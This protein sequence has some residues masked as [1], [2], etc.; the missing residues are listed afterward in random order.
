MDTQM[1]DKDTDLAVYQKPGRGQA[2]INFFV[3]LISFIG[4]L[5]IFSLL[6]AV[7]Y[8]KMEGLTFTEVFDTSNP[9]SMSNSTTGLRILNFFSSALPLIGA[10][11]LTT[12]LG[13]KK[14]MSALFGNGL[15][16]NRYF[17]LSLVFMA[18]FLPLSGALVELNS[19]LDVS[20]ISESLQSWIIRS[21]QQNNSLYEIIAGNG[22]GMD[23]FL[24]IVLMAMMPAIAEEF[25]FRGLL[26]NIFRTWFRNPHVGIWLSAFVFGAIHMQFLKI[27]P[28]MCLGAVFGY[29]VYWTGSIWPAVIGHFANNAMAVVAL[30]MNKGDYQKVLEQD[31]QLPIYGVVIIAA[32][33]IGLFNY[34]QK[35]ANPKLEDPYA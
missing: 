24:N 32:L 34:M 35:N 23:L 25:F 4:F 22:T 30:T 10:A 2:V 20:F 12:Y 11:M 17:A 14:K 13:F 9:K 8:I 31:S 21:D 29:M 1:S 33:L 26:L 3:A 6:A 27:L 28:M 18:L 5:I 16:F 7:I 15:K 19:K